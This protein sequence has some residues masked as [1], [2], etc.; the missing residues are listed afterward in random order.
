MASG[1]VSAFTFCVIS[2]KSLAKSGLVSSAV[3]WDEWGCSPAEDRK[4]MVGSNAL[5][6]P[7]RQPGSPNHSSNAGEATREHGSGI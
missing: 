3:K 7:E 1:Q 6:M 4:A 5:E 2:G